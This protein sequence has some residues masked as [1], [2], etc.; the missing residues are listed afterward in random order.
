MANLGNLRPWAKGTSGNPRGSS[1]KARARAQLHRMLGGEGKVNA[2]IIIALFAKAT[3]RPELL[4]DKDRD[5][6]PRIREPDL[7]WMKELIALLWGE[8]KIDVAEMLADTE[9]QGE[10]PRR[11]EIPEY[12]PRYEG[13]K[14]TRQARANGKGGEG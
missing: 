8:D 12:D 13:R 1:R 10:A 6:N 3:G 14:R 4:A 9:S 5:G 2:E 7:P 11:I